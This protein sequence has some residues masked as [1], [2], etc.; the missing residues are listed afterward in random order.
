MSYS[1][2]QRAPLWLVLLGAAAVMLV[3]AV[4]VGRQD[5]STA[6]IVG[7]ASAVMLLFAF[8]FAHLRVSDD[9]DHL[10]IQY[11]PLP[12]FGRSIACS[13]ITS[14]EPARA[15]LM[16]GWG[17]H[18]GPR[19]GWIYNLWGFDCVAIQMASSTVRIGTDDPAGLTRFLQGRLGA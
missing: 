8:S 12:L 3:S 1:H 6:V 15:T 18:W 2:T 17:I 11:G 9:G 10:R 13:H 19:R 16:D 14:V 7:I 5:A 4:G